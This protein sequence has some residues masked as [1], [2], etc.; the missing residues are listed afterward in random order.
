[1]KSVR[2]L[3]RF[4]LPLLLT[5]LLA[6]PAFGSE[7]LESGTQGDLAWAIS[8]DGTLT[9]SGTGPI[10]DNVRP[11][12]DYSDRITRVVVE[13]GITA[14]GKF[15][16]A[17]LD[18]VQELLL[19]DTLTRIGEMSVRGCDSL[20]RIIVPEGVTSIDY[21]AFEDC[22]LE[23]IHLPSTLTELDSHAFWQMTSLRQITLAE[24]NPSYA[25]QDG[26]LY[27]QIGGLRFLE[28]CPN[29]IRTLVLPEDVY[30]FTQAA[31]SGCTTLEELTLC[32]SRDWEP[33]SL[34][35]CTSLQS[36]FVHDTN[37]LFQSVDGVIYSKDL[38]TLVRYP[39]G[40]A[41]T[42]TIPEGTG[43]IGRS[44]FEGCAGLTDVTLPDSI[45][46][47]DQ[48]AFRDC[49]GLTRFALPQ[50][51][52]RIRSMV[53]YGCE[54]LQTIDLPDTV[55]A[56]EKHTFAG[57]LSLNHV[58][59]PQQLTELEE[60][61]FYRCQSLSD[62]LMNA[63]LS[64][65]GG[66]AFDDTALTAVVLPASITYLGESAFG[67]DALALVHALG[68]AP[69]T[70]GTP[71]ASPEQI[72]L[73]RPAGTGWDSPDWAAYHQIPCDYSS[74]VLAPD[75]TQSGLSTI[76]CSHCG[77]QVEMIL[78]PSGHSFGPWF[79][80]LEPTARTEGRWDRICA[81]CAHTESIPVPSVIQEP[82]ASRNRDGQNCIVAGKLIHSYLIPGP[83]GTFQRLEYSDGTLTLEV[84]DEDF[85]F[86][87]RRNLP[88]ELPLFGG[89][90]QG[91]EHYFLVF[92]Q[93][94]PQETDSTEVIRVVR[95]SFDWLR[96]ESASL[97][98]AN[99]AEPF[100]SGSLRM[101]QYADMLYI[102][103][104]HRMYQSFGNVNH[105]ANLMLS[106]F[107]PEMRITDQ[108][109]QVANN[110]T[111]Y[112]SHSFNQFLLIREGK[113]LT[114][115]HGDGYP[116]AAVLLEFSLP[117]G[118]ERFVS[119]CAAQNLLEFYGQTGDNITGA[120]LGG[121]CLS[122]QALLTAGNSA[123]QSP[124]GKGTGTRN[125]FLAVTSPDT[126]GEGTT[127]L[128][129]IT[130]HPSDAALQVST[131]HLVPIHDDSFLL[132]WTEASP[133]Y[134]QETLRYVFLDGLGRIT[135]PIYEADAPLSD[136]VPI[137]TGGQVLWYVTRSWNPG[138][139]LPLFC[140][141]DLSAPETVRMTP[142]PDPC[143]DGHLWDGLTCTRCG[144]VRENPFS[145]VTEGDYFFTPVL[146]AVDEGITSGT[147]GGRFSPNASCTR[148]QV[149]TFLWRA[150]GQPEPEARN[151]PFSD[152]T[153]T[154]YFCNAVLW[155]VEQGIT[156]GTGGGRFSPN[157]PCTR[158]QVVTFLWR[159][160]G[161][162]ESEARDNPFTDVRESDYFHTPVLWAVENGI[163]SGTGEG[164][165]SPNLPCTRAQVVTFLYRA[166][167]NK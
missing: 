39:T 166:F 112:V 148:G 103:T 75:C 35:H 163:T 150:M 33:G 43:T 109:T 38:S 19:P 144:E 76:T 161:Q 81:L 49:T 151:N 157:A 141:I 6:L 156:S 61:A 59:L 10:P 135:S 160:L 78:P 51:F 124:L 48:L 130:D 126:I 30:G 167:A 67:S 147:G 62:L 15:T 71:F 90:Y 132:L 89:F 12:R 74:T 153:E 96:Q 93:E 145:D 92:G 99:T 17:Y 79:T 4:V 56:I 117:A 11:W 88:M 146:W 158:G 110:A 104:A 47:I 29:G 45:Q 77:L 155:A 137:V 116:R 129:W 57:C 70:D 60:Y 37:T 118:Q 83:N 55:T 80:A 34:V 26:L 44:A 143:A 127:D 5:A 72:T 63:G 120:S 133:D 107:I 27:H 152:V 97:Y 31:F 102:H 165:F 159:T 40:R 66:W 2:L 42:Y 52:T 140:S 136:C 113:I 101:V 9:I 21:Q 32:D 85:T 164:R 22:P 162:P 24:G 142:E 68:D 53:F 139:C 73:C 84:Y 25:V 87:S 100:A 91:E 50:G 8:D 122:G 154:D 106:I 111:G 41:G 20:T 128:L 3:A 82:M 125:I 105:Q 123:D 114:L 134:S 18:Q 98:G 13:P 28:L 115:N 16:L 108:L 69:E 86:L 95:Y 149:V 46:S 64:S 58:K 54:N 7:I 131:P 23:S 121:F 138:E 65:I 14:L 119:S 1:M 36:I 94:N